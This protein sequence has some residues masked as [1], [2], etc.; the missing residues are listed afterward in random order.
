MFLR[1]LDLT[2]ALRPSLHPDETLLFVQDAVGLYEGKYKIPEYQNGHAYLTSHRVCYVDNEEPRKNSVAVELKEVDRAELYAG[3]LKSS[4]KVTLYPKESKRSSYAA[5]PRSSLQPSP[6]PGPDRQSSPLGLSSPTQNLANATW[7]CPICSFSN[8]VPSNFDVQTASA[9]TVL[10]PC[11]TCGIKPPL[12]HVV[13]AA[14]AT[15]SNRTTSSVDNRT[16]GN[17]VPSGAVSTGVGSS[18]STS[19]GR[20]CRR[21]TF[22]NHPSLVSC[23]MCGAALTTAPDP[24]IERVGHGQRNESPGPSRELGDD[25]SPVESIKLSFR[26][27]GEKIFHE[28][29]KGSLIQRKWLLQS[30]PMVPSASS[31]TPISDSRNAPQPG[32]SGTSTP[33]R[34]KLVGIA[35]LELRGQELRRNNEIVIGNA[36]EDLEALMTSAKEIIALAES[37]ASQANISGNSEANAIL[38]QS[39]SALGLVTTKDMLGSGSES[40]YLSELS[41]NLAE[42]L[43]DDTKGVLRKEGGIMSLVDLWAVFNRARG[44]VELISP[45]DFEKAAQLWDHLKLPVRLRRFR[46]GLLVVQGRDRTDNKTIAALL[47]WLRD[48]HDEPPEEEVPWDWRMYGRGVTVQE[49]AERFGWS[50]GVAAEEL[51]MAEERG[52]VCREQALDGLRY[53][54]NWLVGIPGVDTFQTWI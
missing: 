12:V 23:E 49:A 33:D 28:R 25:N 6:T 15:M 45:S 4:A 14:L 24:R 37:F 54:E 46:S 43:T 29:L 42:F 40:L 10:P 35:G 30:D 48:L 21:C 39:T 7:V 50:V 47:L 32:S 51:D 5:S 26:A 34:A 31:V 20:Q 38:T 18:V 17:D 36:F 52:A 3:F 2:T 44:G 16:N 8:P 22:I 11:L 9:R 1:H 53:W 41:R 13:K 19:S 27:G